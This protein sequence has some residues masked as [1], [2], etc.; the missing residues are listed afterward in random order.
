MATE[1]FL[2]LVRHGETVGNLEKIAH[3]QSE[4][5][6]NDRGIEQAKHT[7]EML[8]SWERDFH[9]VYTSPLSRAHHTGGHI[10]KSLEL[11]IDTHHDLMEGFLGDLEG[12]TYQELDDF[13]YGRHSIKDDD[14]R[15]HNGESPNQLGDRMVTAVSEL[16]GR[17]P[18]ENLILVSH[19]AAI[20]HF[21]AK[22]LGIG[23]AFGPRYLMH[24]A[25]VT[26]LKFVDGEAPELT[27]LNHHDHIPDDLKV[28]PMKRD[29]HD[30]K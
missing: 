28:H 19:G 4:S 18:E 5:P 8:R 13:G 24:N 12:V 3:G 16:R 23:P 11:P 9:R 7:A 25:A 29:K 2:L 15:A 1:Q 22:L 14:F 26:E 20:A 27:A 30:S 17:H 6:L 21:I 10:A